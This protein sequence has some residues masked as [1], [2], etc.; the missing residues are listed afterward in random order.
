MKNIPAVCLLGET[1]GANPDPRAA[2]EV[3]KAIAKIYGWDIKLEP[4]IKEADQIEQM[5][6]K[7]SEQVGEAEAKTVEVSRLEHLRVIR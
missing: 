4:L 6:H 1:R 7:L 2:M 3:V 5:L